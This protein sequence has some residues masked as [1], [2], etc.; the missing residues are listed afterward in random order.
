M[1]TSPRHPHARNPQLPSRMPIHRYAPFTPI[2]LP[3]RTW[4]TTV[5]T[6]APR[7]C[8]VDLR[9]GNQALIDPMTPDRKRRMF[10]LLVRMGYK[11]IEVGFPA[12][13]QTDFDF[14]RQLVEEDLVPDDVTIQVLTQARDEL[15]ERTFESLRGAE[16]AIV[17]LYNSTRTLQRRVVFDSDRAGIVDIAVHGAQLVHK[18][19][20]QMGDTEIRYQYSPSPSPAPSSSSRW[21]SA[22]PSPTSGSRPPT[23]RRSSTCR[24]PSRWPS[25][26]STPTRSSGC[27]ATSAGATPSCSACTRTTTAA[28]PSPPPSWVTAPAPTAS[29]AACSATASAPATSTWSPSA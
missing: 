7:W 6:A 26:P 10:D 1:S 27:T 12:A 28:P 19:A 2:D 25:P 16:Q 14:V 18:L 23:G 17:H 11:E 29:R 24:R 21:R 20:E 5:T 9:D 3:D 13:S 8:A 4:R 15:I 22:T